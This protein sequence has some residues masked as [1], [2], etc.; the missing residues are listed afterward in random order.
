MLRLWKEFKPNANN[1]VGRRWQSK[2]RI[3][4]SL[5]SLI[6]KDLK[7]T[8][9]KSSSSENL[10]SNKDML[11]NITFSKNAVSVNKT[12]LPYT[13]NLQSLLEFSS[14]PQANL[15]TFENN[16]WILDR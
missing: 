3:S 8:S 13:S 4:L 1:T 15:A 7:K 12:S 14:L 11:N 10:I 16:S 9:L 5:E 6:W 2:A